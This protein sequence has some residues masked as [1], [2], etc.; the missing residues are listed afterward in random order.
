MNGPTV[1]KWRRSTLKATSQHWCLSCVDCVTITVPKCGRSTLKVTSQQGCL[2]YVDCVPW[3]GLQCGAMKLV[4]WFHWSVAML[5]KHVSQ[6]EK[7]FEATSWFFLSFLFF[8]F[9]DHTAIFW[10]RAADGMFHKKFSI[11]FNEPV[12]SVSIGLRAL[13][14]GLSYGRDIVVNSYQNCPSFRRCAPVT[15]VFASCN[16]HKDSWLCF[17]QHIA[18]CKTRPDSQ[19]LACLA[20][21]CSF[22]GCCTTWWVWVKFSNSPPPPLT[23][24]HLKEC[25]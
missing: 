5:F 1:S 2:S 21:L 25:C 19:C 23:S 8:F 13:A 6:P 9:Q 17:L 18:F 12:E 24:S 20:P 16:S 7:I 3:G 14:L 15:Q 4:I 10:S 11:S 22:H